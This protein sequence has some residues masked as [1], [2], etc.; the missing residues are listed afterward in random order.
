MIDSL[1]AKCIPY[2]TD[3]VMA[4]I[5]K[6]EQKYQ[7]ALRIAKD[8]RSEQLPCTHKGAHAHDCLVQR[9]TQHKC[10]IMAMVGSDLK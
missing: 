4:G 9:I 10:Y 8:P 1:H 6:L 2:I 7:V 5:E 3:C